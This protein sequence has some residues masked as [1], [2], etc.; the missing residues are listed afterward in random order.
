M[1]Q[2]SA[3]LLLFDFSNSL[4]DIKQEK[5]SNS[6][7]FPR[8]IRGRSFALFAWTINFKKSGFNYIEQFAK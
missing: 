8:Y 3:Y 6:F 5:S 4:L 1:T 2:I 7:G